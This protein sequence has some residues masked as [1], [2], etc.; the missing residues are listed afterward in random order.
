MSNEQI[1]A[2]IAFA[3]LFWILGYLYGE[4]DRDEL[5]CFRRTRDRGREMSGGYCADRECKTKIQELSV[6]KYEYYEK[7]GEANGV[8]YSLRAELDSVKLGLAQKS[9]D[10]EETEEVHYGPSDGYD[11]VVSRLKAEITRLENQMK[12][13]HTCK[14]KKKKRI[15]YRWMGEV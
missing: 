13:P 10:L 8:I 12:E 2:T 9:L 1:A 4:K 7:W 3:F 5:K 6:E 15:P 14:P 11:D